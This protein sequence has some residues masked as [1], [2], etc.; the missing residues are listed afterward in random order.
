MITTANP[1]PQ[2][3]LRRNAGLLS[4][5]AR[6]TVDADTIIVNGQI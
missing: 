5:W 3:G 6:F 2:R 4:R 1:Q